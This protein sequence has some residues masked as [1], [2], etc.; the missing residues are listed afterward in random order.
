M[1]DFKIMMRRRQIFYVES[2]SSKKNLSNTIPGGRTGKT[3]LSMV[4]DTL[5]IQLC[6]EQI[7]GRENFKT[8]IIFLVC[9]DAEFE[10]KPLLKH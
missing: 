6:T 4:F 2:G 8:M 5:W 9:N 3:H 1:R 7:M 10:Q